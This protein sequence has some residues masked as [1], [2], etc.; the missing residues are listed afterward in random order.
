MTALASSKIEENNAKNFVISILGEEWPLSAK[1]IYNRIRKGGLDVSYQAV[2]KTIKKLVEKDVLVRKGR[3]YSLNIIWIQKQRE[4]AERIEK[5]YKNGQ[6]NLL[7]L[8][9]GNQSSNFMVGSIYELY[10]FVL[11]FTEYLQL[12]EPQSTEIAIDHWDHVWW[13][14]AGSEKE[15]EKFR[16]ILRRFKV[17][18]ILCKGNTECDRMLLKFFTELKGANIKAKLGV[19]YP[20]SCDVLIAGDFVIQV[21]FPVEMRSLFDKIYDSFSGKFDANLAKMYEENI[22]R[23]AEINVQ[24]SRSPELAKHYKNETIKY[25]KE[26]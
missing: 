17:K 19:N 24:V 14:L 5:A 25:F 7:S 4:F 1:I 18:Y 2:H 20:K 8:F 9:K 21:Y 15:H 3:E 22:S 23:K 26:V 12:N 16:S 6:Q 11:D 13:V 10:R